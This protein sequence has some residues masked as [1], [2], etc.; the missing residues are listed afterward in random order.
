MEYFFGRFGHLKNT[1]HFLKKVTF[2]LASLENSKV[3]VPK[4][5]IIDGPPCTDFRHTGHIGTTDVLNN[6]PDSQNQNNS[7]KQ[8]ADNIGLLQ[9][10]MMSKGGYGDSMCNSVPYVPHII[11]ARS[12]DEVRRK[13]QF[14]PLFFPPT[15]HSVLYWSLGGSFCLRPLNALKSIY[16]ERFLIYDILNTGTWRFLTQNKKSSLHCTIIEGYTLKVS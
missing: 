10:Q 15:R 5:H 11:N 4:Q 1:L 12:L 3:S 9:N 2:S 8:S 16:N 7:P 13:W 6:A 14:F